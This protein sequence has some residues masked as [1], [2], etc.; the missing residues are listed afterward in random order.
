MSY[1]SEEV[2]V[3]VAALE[4]REKT[5]TTRAKRLSYLLMGLTGSTCAASLVARFLGPDKQ[6]SSIDVPSKVLELFSANVPNS[7]G[8]PFESAAG[9][10]IN[11]VASMRPIM[12][13]VVLLCILIA[14][15]FAVI[16]DD[17]GVTF[18]VVISSGM[19]MGTL[20][21]FSFLFS[22]NGELVG[23]QA[24]PRASFMEAVEKHRYNAVLEELKAVKLDTTTAGAYV[25]AQMAIAEGD[26]AAKHVR[27]DELERAVALPIVG[28]TF[29]RTGEALYAIEHAAFGAPKSPAAVAYQDER[30]ARQGWAKTTAV[31]L[32]TLSAAVGCL[33][34]GFLALRRILAQRV[35][36]IQ[37]LL[38]HAAATANN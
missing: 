8:M 18:K 20:F 32:G 6:P 24:S 25:L 23:K 7:G 12:I 13:P 11:A 30:L 37:A 3:Q 10:L 38:E 26:E 9:A 16:K 2:R 4:A 19:L 1:I 33:A 35:Y 27:K 29:T 34:L 28:P 14:V 36:R 15:G 17:M 5:L 31:V 22:M 21:V